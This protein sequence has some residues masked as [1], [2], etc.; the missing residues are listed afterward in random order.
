[1]IL[2]AF[3]FSLS[4]ETLAFVS[5]SA[6]PKKGMQTFALRPT[7]ASPPIVVVTSLVS[8]ISMP[9]CLAIEL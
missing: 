3:A 6:P 4:V 5:A 8:I 7:V 2:N 9:N 1:M